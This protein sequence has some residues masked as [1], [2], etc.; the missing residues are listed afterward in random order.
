MQIH[1]LTLIAPLFLAATQA[2]VTMPSFLIAPKPVQTITATIEPLP[3]L[4]YQPFIY[5]PIGTYPN[6]Y[7]P[8][9]CTYGVASMKGN[10]PNWGNANNWANAASASG[11]TVSDVPII[12][13]V[14][15]SDRGE[16]GH[17][18]TVVDIRPGEVLIT[19][20]NYDYHGSVRTDWQPTADYKYI[21]I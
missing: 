13:S 14:A 4:D 8:G 5:A 19:E 6:N 21:Y 2:P 16:F 17:V 10:I 1:K 12:G 18:A 9:Q 20:Q 15:Q 3:T 7:E 11:I